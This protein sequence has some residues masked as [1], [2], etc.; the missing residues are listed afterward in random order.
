MVHPIT[1]AELAQL[2]ATDIVVDLIDVREP[3]EWETGRIAGSRLVPLA[4][5]RADPDAALV[6]GRALVFI[7]A[8]GVRSMSAAKLAERF[9][10]E[11]IYNLEGGT[12]EWAAQGLAL[13]VDSQVVAA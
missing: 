8:R 11:T 3:H 4:D 10:Y 5:F 7:C 1:P 13:A 9:G 12:R 2:L 6:R